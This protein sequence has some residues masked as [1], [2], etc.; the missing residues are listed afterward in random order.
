MGE[1]WYTSDQHFDHAAIIQ[2][3]DRP[4][5]FNPDDIKDAVRAVTRMNEH[6]I[7]EY[8]NLVAPND[9]V[10]HLGDFTMRGEDYR[11]R[12]RKNFIG[13]LNGKKHLILGS[14]DEFGPFD[15]VKMG[16]VS[17]HTWYHQELLD[18]YLI[19]DPAAS[20][21]RKDKL[22]LCGHVHQFFKT[23]KNVINVGVD[24]WDYKP[25]N[26]DEI[27]ELGKELGF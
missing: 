2:Y 14:H 3:C 12:V 7:R 17:V 22:W 19:H 23:N 18:I 4:F 16:F 13:R 5:P 11:G 10:W 15:Y 25:V 26:I 9:E 1:T 20:I 8:N 21:I 27:I 24:V 6:L